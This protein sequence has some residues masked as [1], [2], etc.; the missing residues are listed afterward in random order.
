MLDK[1]TAMLRYSTSDV[2]VRTIETQ[3]QGFFAINVYQLTHKLFSGKQSQ[4]IQREM[5]ERGDAVVVIPYDV[6]EDKVLLI[7]QFRPGALR[8]NQNPWLLEFIAGMFG[9]DESPI[10]VAIREAKE[11]ADIQ[12]TEKDIT[13]IMKYLSSP[14]GMSEC[15]HLYLA[16]IDSSQVDVGGVFGLDEENEDILLHL[17]PREEALALL[18]AGKITNAST[19]IALQWLAL[20]YQNL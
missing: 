11:E 17:V 2:E 5:F 14:G 8:S 9:Q 12:I 4:L 6:K 15:M 3:Y 16:K 7:E 19:I 18:S 20:N 13:P 10:D 1:N